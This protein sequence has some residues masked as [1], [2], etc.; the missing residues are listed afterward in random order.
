[1]VGLTL[2]EWDLFLLWRVR[3]GSTCSDPPPLWVMEK[4]YS[5]HGVPYHLSTIPLKNSD[6][7]KIVELVI[8]LCLKKNF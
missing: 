7:F 2:G 4:L 6:L 3:S 1:M 5:P 8:S